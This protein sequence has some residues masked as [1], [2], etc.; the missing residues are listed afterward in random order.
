M[1]K[2]KSS[3]KSFTERILSTRA[4]ENELVS[5]SF[6]KSEDKKSNVLEKG[7][8]GYSVTLS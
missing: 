5:F 2:W 7:H 8:K 4:L 3:K 1:F 6:T